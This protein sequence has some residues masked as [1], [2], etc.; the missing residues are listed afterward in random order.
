MWGGAWDFCH[1]LFSQQ[2]QNIKSTNT[3][4]DRMLDLE[5][6]RIGDKEL[7]ATVMQRMALTCRLCRELALPILGTHDRYRCS[8]GNQ[9][10]GARHDIGDNISPCSVILLSFGANKI[11]VI[12]VVRAST[13]LDLKD[14]ID[15]VAGAPKTIRDRL[16]CSDARK[17]QQD[18]EGAGANCV[19]RTGYETT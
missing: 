2:S 1:V 14:A 12:K 18:L 15:L 9:F 10:A 13:G 16:S 19:I 7:L 5:V 17:L 11:N 6:S 3:V 4:N 8:C